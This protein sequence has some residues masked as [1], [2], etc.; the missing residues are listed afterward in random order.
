[1][2]LSRHLGL[3]LLA[4]LLYSATRLPCG[5]AQKSSSSS[6]TGS[7]SST[8]AFFT[9]SSS[10]SNATNSSTYS[11]YS[12]S[13]TGYAV[14]SGSASTGLI[15]YGVICFIGVICFTSYLL[16]RYARPGAPV[17]ALLLTWLSW[18]ITFS[19]CFLV[20][21]DLLPGRRHCTRQRVAHHLLDRLPA[22]V[23]GHTILQWLL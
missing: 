5:A 15:I 16:N 11:N 1:M 2:R 12:S 19:I 22:H 9:S 17:V 13:S 3:A 8:S 7:T 10:P 21:I 18:L 6:S 4:S 14:I 20:P 23:A